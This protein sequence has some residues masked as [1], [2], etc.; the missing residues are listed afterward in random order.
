ML[1]PFD[2]VQ[3]ALPTGYRCQSL[4][5]SAVEAKNVPMQEMAAMVQIR[6]IS[7]E[8]PITHVRKLT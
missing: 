5:K 6:L 1:Y 3:K 7:W 2:G 4:Q 8:L